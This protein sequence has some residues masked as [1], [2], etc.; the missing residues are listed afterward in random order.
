MSKKEINKENKMFDVFEMIIIC[1]SLFN[2]SIK[3]NKDSESHKFSY[4]LLWEINL[5]LFN[6][7]V[8]GR[9]NR[10]DLTWDN[11]CTSRN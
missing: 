6:G 4:F 8:V 7:Q 1:Q 5:D 9:H 3:A 11:K 10:T 2:R